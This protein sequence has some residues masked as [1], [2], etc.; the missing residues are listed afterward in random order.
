M[1]KLIVVKI[2][3]RRFPTVYHN[4]PDR[5]RKGASAEIFPVCVVVKLRELCKALAGIG[6]RCLRRLKILA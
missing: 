4:R 3:V 5:I 6:K 2:K 1:E